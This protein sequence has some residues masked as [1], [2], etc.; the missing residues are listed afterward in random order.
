MGHPATAYPPAPALTRAEYFALEETAPE[1]RRY[2]FDGTYVWAMAGASPEHNQLKHNVERMLGNNLS[3][4]RVTS[5]DQRVQLKDRYVY[6][7]VVAFC[8]EGRYTDGNPPSLLNP[9]LV[10]EVLSESTMDK[11]L[12]WK[13]EAYRSVGSIQECWYLWT[14]QMKLD[15]YVRAEGDEWRIVPLRGDEATLR[16]DGFGLEV[17]LAE[18][19]D[20]VL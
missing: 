20:L 6:P 16:S 8:E 10:V 4:C 11:D 1:G 15:R 19:Y 7:D 3:G 14:D 5:S 9:E 18:L 13:L 12:L 2:E 17:P